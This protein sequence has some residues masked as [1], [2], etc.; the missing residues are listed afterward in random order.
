MSRFVRER[1]RRHL[2]CGM[3]ASRG[4]GAR[5]REF[6]RE[7]RLQTTLHFHYK[8]VEPASLPSW[9]AGWLPV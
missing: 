6:L 2:G 3:G 1:R 7:K 5:L 4:V 9:L 8:L